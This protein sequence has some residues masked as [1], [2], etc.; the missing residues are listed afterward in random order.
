MGGPAL[1]PIALRCVY[2][3][4]QAVNVPIIGTGGVTS[5]QDA[6]EM[7]MAGATVVGVGTAIWYR[8]V[9]AVGQIGD[10]LAAFMGQHGYESVAT[11]RSNS[12][13]KM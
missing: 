6:A 9:E 4:A 12:F 1:K 7:V 3:I 13:A 10:E 11:M 8:G 2:E 5:G